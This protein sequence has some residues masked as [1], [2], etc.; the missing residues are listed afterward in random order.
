MILRYDKIVLFTD[1]KVS[2]RMESEDME[3]DFALARYLTKGVHRYPR[4]R[5]ENLPEKSEGTGFL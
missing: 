4:A 3:K 2:K 5:G 1:R